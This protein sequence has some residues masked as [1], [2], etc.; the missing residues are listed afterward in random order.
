[1][2]S[3]TILPWGKKKGLGW[4]CEYEMTIIGKG[5]SRETQVWWCC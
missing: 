4:W 3:K 2:G 1:M 5:Q